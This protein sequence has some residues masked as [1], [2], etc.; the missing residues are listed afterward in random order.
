MYRSKRTLAICIEDNGVGIPEKF[1]KKIFEIFQSI[2]DNERSTGIGLSIVK[3]IVD[4]YQGKV[5]IESELGKGT[6]FFFTLKKDS[7]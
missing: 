4:R 6:K 3:K 5:W 1:H 7:N 2:G